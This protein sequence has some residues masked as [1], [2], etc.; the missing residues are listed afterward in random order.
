MG[1]EGLGNRSEN[2]D[3]LID[4]C[5]QNELVIGGTLFEHKNIH[6]YTWTS[7]DGHP[8]NQIDHACGCKE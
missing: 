2:R 5:T 1:R 6:K 7:P 8:T 4:F 3:L